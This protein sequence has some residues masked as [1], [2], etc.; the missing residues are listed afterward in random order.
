[1][2][3]WWQIALIVFVCFVITGL[4][5]V[6]YRKYKERD[7]EANNLSDEIEKL[8]NERAAQGET[9][10]RELVR[11]R[12]EHTNERATLNRQHESAVA[13][14][15]EKISK[16]ESY[17][18]ES[19]KPKLTVE[20]NTLYQSR[21]FARHDVGTATPLDSEPV[22]YD[23][24]TIEANLKIRFVNTDIH[25][26]KVLGLKAALFWVG[27]GGKEKEIALEESRLL[28]EP[29]IGG[30]RVD[31]R[32]GIEVKAIDRTDYYS[33]EFYMRLKT[34]Y[35]ERLNE[36]SFL[37]LTMTA[38]R[39]QHYS[40]DIYVDWNDA[41]QR[42]GAYITSETVVRYLVHKSTE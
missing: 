1:M 34:E 41:R 30:E 9:H 15:N 42:S 7:K 33:F 29:E 13:S 25:P 35:G 37:R 39:Q 17:L 2:N 27:R 6:P 8:R 4:I 21:V 38:M 23:C 12:Q 5:L 18:E 20:V 31:L 28:N 40:A 22:N 36:H 10:K 14:L 11:L 24:Y 32:K 16:L 26:D 3:L 19:N